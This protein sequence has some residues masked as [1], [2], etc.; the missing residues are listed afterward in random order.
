M[1]RILSLVLSLAAAAACAEPSVVRIDG[2]PGAQRLL[3]N[4]KPFVIQGAGGGGSKKVLAALG[5]NSFRTWGSDTAPR[6][7]DEAQ[8]NGL[9]VMVGIWLGHAEHG[10]DY[11]NPDHLRGTLEG[12]LRDVAAVK[13]HSALLGW[14]LGNEMEMNNPHQEE[15]WRFINELAGRVK[16]LDPNHPVGTVIAEIYGTKAADI[17]RLCPNLDFVGINTYGGGASA[18]RRYREAGGTKP[19]FITEF[20]IPAAWELGASSWGTP[21][22]PSSTWKADWY[23]DV[24]TNGIA[25]YRGKDC[26]GSFAFVWGSKVEATPTW[27]GL[28]LPDGTELAAAEA[29]QELWGATRP[30]NL[31][32]VIRSFDLDRDDLSAPDQLVAASVSA[33]DPDGDALRYEWALVSEG[34]HY[35]DV[36]LGAPLPPNHAAAIVEGQGTPRAKVRLPGHGVYRLY[37]YV[38]DGCG[39][40]AYANRPVRLP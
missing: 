10:F 19:W 40:A 5:A 12:A 15:M 22:E 17:E 11:T 32:P 16:A 4:G 25:P 26:L 20:G 3:V 29:L 37:V 18:G 8:R 38:F 1:K 6:D 36:G 27:H 35:N 30:T 2:A 24:Y 31:C 13:D 23:R 7:L 21:L 39:H 14:T 9:M 33:V 34:A 28:L